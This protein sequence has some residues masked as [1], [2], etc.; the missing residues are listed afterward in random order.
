MKGVSEAQQA[1]YIR[2]GREARH[3]P[4]IHQSR[5]SLNS[6]WAVSIRDDLTKSYFL[7]KTGVHKGLYAYGSLNL[8][9][10]I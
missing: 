5:I 4:T 3:S 1:P 8:V 6:G 2:G 10:G 7:V 9:N